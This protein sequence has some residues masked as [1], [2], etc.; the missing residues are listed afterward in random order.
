MVEFCPEK[1]IEEVNV[2][3]AKLFAKIHA[4]SILPQRQVIVSEAGAVTNDT[5]AMRL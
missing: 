3:T 4:L 1:L 2:D 5:L